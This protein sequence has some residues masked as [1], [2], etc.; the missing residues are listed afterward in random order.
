ME[1]A[2]EMARAKDAKE[3]M[4][5]LEW[6]Q[7]VLEATTKSLSAAE[8]TALVD[9]CM[10]LLKDSNFR[11]SQGGLQA[12]SA[13]AVLSGEHFKLHFNV[14]VP[15]VVEKLGDGKQPVR[16]AARQLLVTLME[17]SSPTLIVE[18]AGTYAWTHRSWRIREEFA[19]TV[20]TAIGLFASTELPLQRVLLPP[21]LQLLSDSNQSVRGASISC[22]EEMYAHFG[23]Q[24]REELQ[25]QHLPSR[26]IKE[27]NA[28]LEKIEPKVKPIDGVGSPNISAEVRP[29][30]TNYKRSPKARL[31]PRETSFSS[32]EI[33]ATE[34]PVAPI[35]VYSE[36]E[37]IK[38]IEKISFTLVPEKDWSLRIAAMQRVEGLM[39]GGA[40]DYPS[41][42]IL[43]KQLVNPL[44]TQL[45]DRRSSIVKQA[46]HLLSL[47]SKELLGDFETC[48]ELLIPVLLKLVVITVLVIAESADNC[49]KTMLRNCKVACL[50]PRITETAKNDKSAVLRA[51]CCEYALL[52]LEYWADAPEIQHSVDLYEDLIKCCVAD[53]MSEVRSTARKCYSLFRKTWPER[54]RRLFLSF[55]PA[56][57]R[58]INEEDGGTH[59]RYAS[60][61]HERGTQSSRAP[62]G[63]ITNLP[64]YGTSAIVAM[65]KSAT[66]STDTFL[67]T[68]S[69][70]SQSKT[71]GNNSE[72]RL[73]RVLHASKQKVS[74]IESLLKGVS[75]SGKNFASGLSTSLD[76]G[77]D[78]PSSRDPPVPTY[79][80]SSKPFSIQRSASVDSSIANI[81]K[82]SKMIGGLNMFEV[83]NSLVQSTRDQSKLSY[84]SHVTSDTLSALS[85]SYIRKP[86][87]LLQGGDS[88]DNV[89]LRTTR[90]F[91]NLQIDKQYLETSYKD[92][93]YSEVHNG[94][95]PNFQRPL[96]RKHASG[97]VIANSKNSFD[98]GQIPATEMSNFIDG[99]VSLNDALMI[100]LNTS[101]D[102]IARVS[103]FNYLQSLLQ[104]GPKGILEV[105]LN[106]E[107]IMKLF[108]RYLDDPHHKVAQATFS[109]L[110]EV[111]AACRK[112]FESYLERTLPHVF[113]RLIDP[114]EMVRQPCSA[115]LEIVGMIYNVDSLLPAVIRSLD[116]QRSPKAKLAVIQFA[117]SSF[118]K[119]SINSDDYSS[120][121]FLR[122]WL[123]KL[124]PL[125]NH[126]NARL[127]EASISG[128]VSVYSHFD[129][130]AVLNFILSFSVEEQ[131]LL[132]RALKKHM[133]RIEVDLMNF[134]QN[135]KERH[136]SKSFHDQS[137]V[138]GISSEEGYVGGPKTVHCF[139]HY[140]PVPVGVEGGRK[141]S[142]SQESIQLDASIR[143]AT[144]DGTHPSFQILDSCSA[145]PLPHSTGSITD[146]LQKADSNIDRDN[147]VLTPC[148]DISRLISSDKQ[149]AIYLNNSN[150]IS[151]D[152]ELIQGKLS[153]VK[154]NFQGDNC[155]SVSQL[156]HRI[157]N[158]NDANSTSD[159]LE[160][161]QQFIQVSLENDS[162]LWTKY[163]NQ[164][165]TA[166][167]EV[168]DNSDLSIQELALSLVV[169]MLNNQNT[170]MEESIEIVLPK[171]L[172]VKIEASDKVLNEV[173]QCLNIVLSQF[174][175]FRSLD[176]IVPLLANDD[177]KA[178]II[179]VD[180][181]TRLV[182]RLAHGDLIKHL[183]S[184]LPALFH[185]FRNQSPNV[186]KAVVFCLV[187][188]YIMLGKS[189]LPYLEGLS[190]TQLRLVTIYA[191]RISQA[192]SGSPMDAN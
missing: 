57:Q 19:R 5:G 115:T 62:Q 85:L 8:V 102:W 181:L 104:E 39:F 4:A 55:D 98:D 87:E 71:L 173:N 31:A 20:T 154:A 93:G 136:H 82:G 92:S 191:N 108:F 113:S 23:S 105:T 16:D 184:F 151:K 15:A 162:S 185:A 79:L 17:V 35:K 147:P 13:A 163:F 142:S 21:V 89:N 46:S 72:R 156:L 103:A 70:L 14:L 112:P 84:Q 139:S 37:L 32:G 6:L 18:R 25:R 81:M 164:I 88:E 11:V 51:R 76:L 129:S 155:F 176:V 27:I 131:N 107:K 122:L 80:P 77:V 12:L 169:R 97:R 152:S 160:A 56:I 187:E 153:S 38:E 172:R 47:L 158:V 110:A 141:W 43:L 29:S 118:S 65:D 3:R 101:S 53:A 180:C 134:L 10:D 58:I 190:S 114:K 1:K 145:D 49:I 175:P 24:F 117:N 52:M 161:L 50:L 130:T 183:P 188:I 126:K 94:Y 73:E 33:D 140:F 83:Q 59:K 75:N 144:F 124:A 44:S 133:P 42:P 7:Q 66:I 189:F 78:A 9:A 148:L 86:S 2:L 90:R 127:K 128:I 40:A 68:T 106:F 186:R 96:L 171:I 74:A 45:L 166:V 54:S 99:P 123:A 34:N 182:G 167:F 137:D 69:I 157:C 135:K 64:G 192:R 143:S 149:K 100:G 165:L 22:I 121:S 36:K 178:L 41:F 125:V 95:I 138:I 174:N 28:R 120:N 60:S 179:C 168:M 91:L 111:I 150:G 170:Q 132:R 48:S 26:M 116:E 159:K 30:F 146:C 109:T 119:H 67:S 177:E 63:T 61:L